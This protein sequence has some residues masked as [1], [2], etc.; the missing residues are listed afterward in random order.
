MKVRTLKVLGVAAL[1]AT[2]LT[3]CNQESEVQNPEIEL[4]APSTSQVIPGQ[5]IVVFNQDFSRSMENGKLSYQ[6]AQENTKSQTMKLMADAG[7]KGEVF[8]VYSKT[9]NG[10]AI[11]L[12]EEGADALRKRKEVAYVEED[13][14]VALAPGGKGKPGGGG[15]STSQSTPYGITRVG[16]GATYT[17]SNAAWVVDT[18]IDLNHE[19]LNVDASRG[20]NAFT[21]GKDGRSLDDGNGHGSHVAGTIAA[22][23]NN[24]GVIG[25]AAGATV[26]PV[27][28]L[29]S[30]GSGSYSGVVAGVDYVGANAANG[31]VANL[32]LGGPVSQALDDAVLAASEKGV[33]FVLAAGNDGDDAN[34]HSPARV[35][36]NNIYTISAMDSNDRLASF[37][38]YGNPPVDFAAPG[39]AIQST[40]K[41]GGYNTIS[42]TSMAAPHAA[43]ILLWGNFNSGGTVNGDPDGNP[44]TIIVR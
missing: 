15:G 14:I 39:V 40:W 10:A 3:S 22:I 30:R 38:N 28:V 2:F 8:N 25:V 19:D 7:I 35:N 24:L 1:T 36:G 31:D 6:K 33:K 5:Y 27:K 18:G 29:D 11:K 26:I 34:N 41:D 16:G 4:V 12:S 17:G 20:F 21:S 23:D 13:R 44:D 32:S 42:G 37:S 9:I 43:G